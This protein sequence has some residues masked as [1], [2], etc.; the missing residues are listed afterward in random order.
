MPS[1]DLAKS[2]RSALRQLFNVDFKAKWAQNQCPVCSGLFALRGCRTR[3]CPLQTVNRK[4]HRAY[5]RTRDYNFNISGLEGQ[6]LHGKTAGVIGTGKIAAFFIDICRGFGMKVIA[7]AISIRQRTAVSTMSIWT[8][9][10][11]K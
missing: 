5:N 8:P 2:H 3:Y 10:S 9:F 4:T 1:A 7:Y 11:G 6:D